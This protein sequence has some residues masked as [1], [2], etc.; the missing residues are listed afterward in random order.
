MTTSASCN[1]VSFIPK[2]DSVSLYLDVLT[3]EKLNL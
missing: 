3:K 2:H 1:L